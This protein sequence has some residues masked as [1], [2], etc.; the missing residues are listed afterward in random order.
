MILED[1]LNGKTFQAVIDEEM[2]YEQLDYD[3]DAIWS[4][5]L[6]SGY[7]KI[8]K[9]EKTRRGVDEYTFSL[10]NLEARFAFDEIVK[11]LLKFQS[12]D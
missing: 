3:V 12:N 9:I 7:L 8:N 6:A 5:F 10:T 2:I 4:L 1:L 11:G